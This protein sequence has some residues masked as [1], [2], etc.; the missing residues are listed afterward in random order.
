MSSDPLMQFLCS[1]GLLS[2]WGTPYTAS[3]EISQAILQDH[4]HYIYGW[5]FMS[6]PCEEGLA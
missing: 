1:E 2:P 5:L 6:V 3:I 4:C